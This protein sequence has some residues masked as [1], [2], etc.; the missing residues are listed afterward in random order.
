[1]TRAHRCRQCGKRT[2][3][4]YCDACADTVKCPHGRDIGNCTECDVEGD[5]AHD[6]TREGR[7]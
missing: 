2:I 7:P 3:Y 5:I 1:M 4:V 6:S